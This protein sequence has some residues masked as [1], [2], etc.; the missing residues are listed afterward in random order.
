MRRAG[1]RQ[2]M[3]H[4]AV[5]RCGLSDEHE[6]WSA[7]GRRR[8][9]GGGAVVAVAGVSDSRGGVD[10]LTRGGGAEVCRLQRRQRP[11]FVITYLLYTTMLPS[12]PRWRLVWSAVSGHA[13]ERE[14]ISFAS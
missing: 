14:E 3:D 6:G 8:A 1:L 5:G 9:G 7:M 10:C 11:L 4:D 12:V 13:W 2:C